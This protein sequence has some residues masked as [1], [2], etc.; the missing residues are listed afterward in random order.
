MITQPASPAHTYPPYS[1]P[2][3]LT[4]AHAAMGAAECPFWCAAD[5]VACV[6]L[7]EVRATRSG[8]VSGSAA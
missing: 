4:Q 8:E 3:Y 1:Y 6:L 5:D 7:L 2:T